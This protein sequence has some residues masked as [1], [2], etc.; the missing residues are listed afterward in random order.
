MESPHQSNPSVDAVYCVGCNL[1]LTLASLCPRCGGTG[2]FGTSSDVTD[3][4]DD[5]PDETEALVGTEL[6][7]LG[8]HV[9]GQY[10][11][12]DL[13]HVDAVLMS[14]QQQI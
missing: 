3:Q 6:D 10:A 8:D 9:V 7:R 1:K 5:G 11:G 12:T 2:V 13:D 4:E 14:G